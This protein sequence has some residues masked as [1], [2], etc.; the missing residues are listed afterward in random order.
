MSAPNVGAMKLDEKMD[1]LHLWDERSAQLGT[2]TEVTREGVD[3]QGRYV[4]TRIDRFFVPGLRN[5]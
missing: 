1:K 4:A 2:D 3:S 5:C